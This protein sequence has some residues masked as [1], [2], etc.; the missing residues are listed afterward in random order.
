ESIYMLYIKRGNSFF[1]DLAVAP[2]HNACPENV[3]Q[4]VSIDPIAFNLFKY[5]EIHLKR[6]HAEVL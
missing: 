3:P 1:G 2:P 5:D 4:S 6:Y